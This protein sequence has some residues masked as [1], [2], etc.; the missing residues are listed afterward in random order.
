MSRIKKF[1]QYLIRITKGIQIYGLV[2]KAGTGKSFRAQLVAA[3]Y[4][5][6][7]IIDDGLLIQNQQ[8]VAGKSAKQAKGPYGA[9]KIA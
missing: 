6:D 7:Y 2:G 8:I 1:Y 3:K 4:N 9:V 5:I